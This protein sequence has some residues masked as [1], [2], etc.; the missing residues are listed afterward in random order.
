M[1]DVVLNKGSLGLADRFFDS[2]QLLCDVHTLPAFFNHGDDAAQVAVGTFQALDDGF[3]TLV[4]VGMVMS[5]FMGFLGHGLS[6][7]QLSIRLHAIPP[8][9]LGQTC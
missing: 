3:M 4:C 6:L 1:I 9:G 7:G 8:G 2:M 5:V